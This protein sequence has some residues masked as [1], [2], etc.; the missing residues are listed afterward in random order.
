MDEIRQRISQKAKNNFSSIN[1]NSFALKALFSEGIETPRILNLSEP[2]KSLN[3]H[4]NVKDS[5]SLNYKRKGGKDKKTTITDCS[6]MK[7]IQ[8][9]SKDNLNDKSKMKSTLDKNSTLFRRKSTLTRL[10]NDSILIC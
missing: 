1:K 5:I 9:Q 3:H 2:K 7:L 4:H 10:F 8:T 6:Q